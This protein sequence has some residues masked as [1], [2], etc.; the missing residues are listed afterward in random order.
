MLTVCTRTHPGNVRTINED[1]S[2]WEPDIST[3][4]VADGMGGH[5]AGEA[6]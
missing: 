5:N 6:C 2:M 1:S 3:L 4:A